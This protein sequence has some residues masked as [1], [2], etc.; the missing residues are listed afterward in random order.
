M[1]KHIHLIG[2]GGS[3][4]SSIA[5]VLLEQGYKVSGS[6]QSLSA[7]AL[8]LRESGAVVYQGHAAEHILGASLVVRSSA[9]SDENPEVLA[10]QQA[11]IPV[12]KRMDFIHTLLDQRESIAVAGSHGKT[13]SS[14][15]LAW[16]L[17]QTGIDAGYI[18]GGTSLN[19]NSNAHSGSSPYF[20]IEADEYDHMFLG[21]EPKI[22]LLT[23]VE[24]DHP[25]CFPTVSSYHTA[26]STFIQQ[27]K[28]GGALVLNADDRGAAAKG[29]NLPAGV[30]LLT[31]GLQHTPSFKAIDLRLNE[32]GGF[33]FT[34]EASG[35][36]EPVAMVRLQIPGE[37]NVLN[38]LGV[39][40]VHAALGRPLQAAADALST[41]L[42]AGRRFEIVAVENGITI[43]DD[44]A[45]HPSKIRATLAAARSRF[46]HQRIIAVWQPHTYS[47]TRSLEG[48][49]LQSFTDADLVIVTDVYTS[50]EKKEPYS[51]ESLIERIDKPAAKFIASLSSVVDYLSDELQPED[52]VLVLSAGDANQICRDL[53]AI[54]SERKG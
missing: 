4:M 50:R 6:D 52:V 10:A 33:S 11:G 22:V 40:T 7:M 51:P 23:N 21:I 20:V 12:M 27:I 47:R 13:T 14:A 5:H 16:S 2:I 30:R 32:A 31:F 9:I 43:I 35:S 34:V 36:S 46:P 49:F 28:P 24:Y 1:K 42:G 15:M 3:G 26:F 45:H 18:L 25:D 53:A 37:H 54:L 39:L 48:D 38:S 44:Y 8:N 19:L 17:Q 41:Y 29:E